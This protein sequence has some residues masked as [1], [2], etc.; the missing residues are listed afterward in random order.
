MKDNNTFFN[1][2]L[3][4]IIYIIAFIIVITFIFFEEELPTNLGLILSVIGFLLCIY[5]LIQAIFF[6]KWKD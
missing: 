4:R 5:I 2:K 6:D 1:P 3:M